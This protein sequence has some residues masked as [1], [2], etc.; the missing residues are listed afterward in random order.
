VCRPCFRFPQLLINGVGLLGFRD[1][2]GIRP[3]VFGSRPSPTR[4][5]ANDYI[6]ASESVAID[7]LRFDLDRDLH[8]GEAILVTL[9]GQVFR[10]ICS[11]SACL[12]PCIFEYVYFAR[13]DSILD[14]VQVRGAGTMTLR[15]CRM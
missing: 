10:H 15:V 6:M 5:G 4:T 12:T 8:P 2:F 7:T 1:A 13:P 3:L 11:P 9:K 14:G